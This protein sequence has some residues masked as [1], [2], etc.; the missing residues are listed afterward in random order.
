M[1]LIWN[2]EAEAMT[3]FSTRNMSKYSKTRYNSGKQ[4]LKV[5][6]QAAIFS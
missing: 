3:S 6:G 2:Y 4:D 1:N 5:I